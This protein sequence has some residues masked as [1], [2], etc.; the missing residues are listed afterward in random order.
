M[1]PIT[2]LIILLACLSAAL[3]TSASAIVLMD[4]VTVGNANNAADP[5][6]GYGA[7]D[8]AYQIGKY[9]VTNAQYCEFLNAKGQSNSNGIYN[10]S[11][12]SYGITQSGSLGNYSYTLT[13]ALANRPVVFV[14]WFDAARFANWMMNG[15][16][17]GDMETGA[18]TLNGAT[19]GIILANA[20]AKVY[21]PSE[22]E[23]YK[24]AY[25]NAANASY[26]RYPNGQ[27]TITTANANYGSSS[28]TDVGAYSGYPSS[29][30]TN[31]QGG[32]AWEWNDA[33]I[34]G[35][36]RG[37]RGGAW[38]DN[39]NG[40]HS[41]VPYNL[42]PTYE[43]VTIGFRLASVPTNRPNCFIIQSFQAGSSTEID[44][45]KITDLDTSQVVYAN[46]F[47]LA[48]DGT[49]GLNSSYWPQ[50]GKDTNNYVLNGQ[51]TRVENGKLIL[52]TTGFN[53]NGSG[54]Y[55]SHSETEP[56]Q[57]LPA[58]FR[59]E[60]NAR[61]LQ[62][63]GH[64]HFLL[65]R[66]FENDTLQ[67]YRLGGALSG[68]RSS[69]IPVDVIRMAASGSWFQDYGIQI[70]AETANVAWAQQ[71]S[72]PP[73]SLQQTHQMAV[74]L[75]G[76]TVSF[77]LDGALLKSTSV[78]DW[79]VQ[80]VSPP[81]G[82]LFRDDFSDAA[83]DSNLWSSERGSLLVANGLMK[84]SERGTIVSKREFVGAKRMNVRLR[85]D[86]W[87]ETVRVMLAT[88]GVAYSSYNELQGIGVSLNWDG[89]QF[90]IQDGQGIFATLAVPLQ[91]QNF[92]DLV[93]DDYGD[94]V[95]AALDGI[96]RIET[97]V[98]AS[99][100]IGNKI[101]YYSREFGAGSS[102]DYISVD[103]LPVSPLS[104]SST[105]SGLELSSGALSPS[106]TSSGT[107]YSVSVGSSVSALTVTPSAT[108][109]NAIVKV[110]GTVVASGTA[111]PSI[112][113]AAG[114]TVVS[115][116]VVSQDGSSTTTYAVVVHRPATQL[117]AAWGL[118]SSGQVG[119][120][121]VVNSS[122]P[123]SV[124]AS[125]V[126]AGK[127]VVAVA[128]GQYHSLALC[129]DGTIGAW[130][131]NSVLYGQLGNGG[132]TNSSVPVVVSQDGVLAGKNVTVISA[133][134]VHNLA[135][136]SDGT[137]AAWG[138]NANGKLGTGGNATS[139]VPVA[140]VQSGVLAGKTVVAVSAGYQH[141][142]ALCS[143]GSIAAWGLNVYGQL[144]N[145]STVSSNVPVLVDQG[146]ALAGKRVISIYAGFYYSMALCSDGSAV[147]WGQNTYGQLGTGSTVNSSV[148]VAVIS[149]G[150]L[151]GK[152]VSA[153][154]AGQ[155]HSMA[156]CTDGSI[157]AWGQNTNGK[158]GNGNSATSSVPVAVN[159]SGVL[160]GKVVVAVAAGSSHSTAL[161]SDGTIAGWGL[162]SYG[163]LGEGSTTS[164][165]VPVMVNQSGVLAG[166]KVTAISAGYYHNVA[167]APTNLSSESRLAAIGL[168][169]GTLSPN[170]DSAVTAY[171]ATV[172]TSS[173]TVIPQV[174]DGGAVVTIN[175]KVV[176]SSA[177]GLVIPLEMG[178]N[179]LRIRGIA[180]D[181]FATTAYT[182]ALTRRPPQMILSTIET[183]DGT[184]A[185]AG[186]YQPD[187]MASLT[188]AA[189]PGYIF[190]HWTGDASGSSNP[191]N[192]TM[193][194]DRSVGAAFD[195]DVSDR[196]GDGFTNYDEIVVHASDPNNVH[197]VPG[198]TDGDG[199]ADTW[200]MNS[201]GNLL[202]SPSGD[203]DLDG[204]SNQ[205]EKTLGTNPTAADTDAD[206]MN[207]G[208]EI[209]AGRNPLKIETVFTL[210]ALLQQFDGAAKSASATTTPSGLSVNFT[211]NGSPIAPSAVGTYVVVGTINDANYTGSANGTL[212]ISKGGATVTLG[213]LTTTYDGTPKSTS[214]TT[215]PNGLSVN[216]TYNGSSTQPANAGSYAVVGT[217]NDASYTGSA[218]ANL[219]IS[220][221]AATVTLGS[222]VQVADGT[223]KSATAITSPAGLTVDFSYNGTSTAPT[224]TGNYAVTGMV[225]DLNYQGSAS[226]TLALV[227][228]PTISV[229]PTSVTANQG[230]TVT[231][232]VAAAGNNLSYQWQKN[233]ADISGA[234]MASLT[235]AQ[236]QLVDEGSYTV[237]ISNLAGNITSRPATLTALFGPGDL[238][239]D[240]LTN[241]E[242]N[243]IYHTNPN[244][245][246]T[247]HDGLTDG[248]EVGIG[249]F[250]VVLG[251]CTWEQARLSAVARGGNLAR[252]TSRAQWDLALKSLGDEAL[253]DVNGL[254]IGANDAAVEGR[255]AWTTGESFSFSLW[256][257]GQP[258][259][260]NNSDY[261]AV[262]GDLGGDTGKWYDFRGVTLRDGYILE[263]GYKTDPTV[264]DA[265]GDGL[266]DAQEQAAS[267]NPF[268]ADTDGDGLSDGQEA[269]LTHTSPTS[270][271]SNANGI[272][273]AQ[274]DADA[275]GLSNLVEVGTKHTD[276]LLADTDGDG[277]SDGAEAL[278]QH[279]DP[280]VAD[281]DGDSYSDG[282]EVLNSSNPR[283]AE[284]FPTYSLTL[285][286]GG[287]VT[288]GR[289]SK[290][291]TLAHG[292][293]ATL[294]AVANAGYVFT[295]WTG[296]LTGSASPQSLLMDGN[297]SVGA[298]F[299]HDTGDA[300]G[301]GLTN[302]EESVTYGT[303]PDLAD[304]DGDGLSDYEE[305][306]TYQ[307]NP[308]VADTDGDGLSDGAEVTTSQ[309]NLLV[310]DTDA[311]GYSDG[312]EVVNSSNPNSVGSFPIYALTLVDGG[313][314]TGG[315]FSAT[316]SL[317]HGTFA[318]LTAVA[319]AGYVFSGWTNDLDGVDTQKSLLMS[320]NKTVG[321][322]FVGDT[323]DDDGDALTNFE[324]SV[325]YGTTPGVL[326]T[327]GD[328][329]SD[330]AEVHTEHTNPLLAD[331]D[332]DGLSDG[333]E[334]LTHHTDPLLADTDGDS[335]SDGY[336]VLHSSNP[337]STESFPTYSLTLVDG[338]V[339]TGGSFSKVGTL[340]HGSTATLTAVANAGYVFTAW[341][342]NLTGSASPQ[343]LLMD[344]NRSVGAIFDHDTG[345]AD[346]DG[347]TNFEESVTYGTRPD[348]A[349]SDGD[350]LSDFTEIQTHQ[351]NP[352]LPDSN[353]DGLAD[354]VGIQMGLD[355]LLDHSA[356]VKIIHDSRATFGL[357]TQQ[358][359]TDLR[360]G[361]TMVRV[362]PSADGVQ[363]RLNVQ[364]STDLLEWQDAGEAIYEQA[365]DP[366][367]PKQFFRFG[368]K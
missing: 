330:G 312:Y 350:G 96:Y 51:K 99:S 317:A 169:N 7:V 17:N 165:L 164:S 354:G 261:A 32:N 216:F 356:W 138:S 117:V 361:S 210:G 69:S 115:V 3:T 189:N 154:S 336:E 271:D 110:N 176:V 257:T 104:N 274:D 310:A 146:G 347:L 316:G 44:D 62:W 256:A 113:L 123:A 105:L 228:S 173:V 159:Q 89:N 191:L 277:L 124:D 95:V 276:P 368:V 13:S 349:D 250:S 332:G 125:G 149:S 126:L 346:S 264:A 65:F 290:V 144:G 179:T 30:G 340:A 196:D 33:V 242:E 57:N 171:S 97:N 195:H 60:F 68:S 205:E 52:E 54:G 23:W 304:S 305:L 222:L 298:I 93:I 268:V 233:G 283:S 306:R 207:D 355:P 131:Q 160:A 21:I 321:A 343:S 67:S 80:A 259:N 239:G 133:G 59:V 91:S 188:A 302:F 74:E 348:L 335:F 136:C 263:I 212:V 147:A 26:S 209:A 56:N 331:T 339:V 49:R 88:N 141:S 85:L 118:N 280:L 360:P 8:H 24:A 161:C 25:Y 28:T 267:S 38:N 266:S 249:R 326:D 289:F 364:K 175:G 77:Y 11:M 193:D 198:D 135:L 282:Y 92:H 241:D 202:Q 248:Y 251:S 29:Y 311:D 43:N 236:A 225:S 132:S 237:K 308:L 186:Y 211:Y 192:L 183:S 297:K 6:T 155:Y 319:S 36:S 194:R 238:D 73:G 10:S 46:T 101:A 39:V 15:Q 102:V 197:S 47:D 120:G 226:G 177:A 71:F 315:H 139:K 303:R 170:F 314:A 265:D 48:S 254:W 199:L 327:D 357:Y 19:N 18:Y 300:D 320:G 286:D 328:G 153:I 76:N 243:T 352:I 190:N 162:N 87:P 337:T 166:M 362:L 35:S 61:R 172:M 230:E 156:L 329:L 122:S 182:V 86:G 287:V 174:L 1:S 240:G 34:S 94:R 112:P 220:K 72:A 366:S 127:T 281:T 140:V 367:A 158:L 55:E 235:I 150:A 363:L 168:S 218:N 41:S 163:Q 227:S 291:G 119:D 142:M 279:T 45:L 181:G 180:Q 152:S 22:N 200:E 42:D 234:V 5:S 301:D 40:L 178:S 66:R 121:T 365:A 232:N 90:S 295:A 334:A 148:P 245:I 2:R 78:E 82:L 272:N 98:S 208:Q 167:L 224:A 16:G 31:D 344:G 116:Q 37:L 206:G 258:D 53:Q 58:N 269:N 323:K 296:N 100:R 114:N 322:S 341:T 201:F 358:D 275:D 338:G 81:S 229:Q 359:L 130:G 83:V 63:A 292:S 333:A 134:Y 351:T 213:G 107:D 253:L 129:S 20:G 106:F 345:D 223:A 324:E 50:G 145:N 109:P 221:G 111:S 9:E 309:T 342:G 103:P 299:D 284:S 14:S 214:V 215:T 128:A 270:A 325:T 79:A 252:F 244:S 4:W 184:I 84:S 294:T 318:Q 247:D 219:V 108:S 27:N 143:D 64:F 70:N 288:G 185:G 203:E 262:S 255:W 187:S 307:S 278:T 293:T 12:A 75:Q 151:A 231:F 285:V 217:I 246:D 353:G 260:L 157:F 204:L 313:S 137:L 273:D